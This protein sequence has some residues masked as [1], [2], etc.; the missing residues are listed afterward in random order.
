MHFPTKSGFFAG[1]VHCRTGNGPLARSVNDCLG[2]FKVMTGN[3][4]HHRDPSIAPLPFNEEMFQKVQ[5]PKKNKIRV[6]INYGSP[7]C[8]VSPAN[9]RSIEMCK[10]LLIDQG[11][12]VVE[13][14]FTSDDLK[15]PS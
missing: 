5:D 6:G 1:E 9:E 4:Q 11:Y 2:M 10:N 15:V 8:P 7:W 12:E 3:N 13:V 14:P